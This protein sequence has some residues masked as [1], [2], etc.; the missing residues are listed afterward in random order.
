M[1]EVGGVQVRLTVELLTTG[2]EVITKML[3]IWI[4]IVNKLTADETIAK[5]MKLKDL[6]LIIISA[7]YQDQFFLQ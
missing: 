2:I 5:E 3:V 7:Y 1:G 6:K 4:G